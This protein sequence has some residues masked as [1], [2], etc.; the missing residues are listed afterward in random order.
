[1]SDMKNMAIIGSYDTILPFKAIGLVD[2]PVK[3]SLEAEKVLL[4]IINEGFGIIYIEEAY[5]KEFPDMI[6][7]LNKEYK[8][9]VIT[10]I[11]GSKGGHDFAIKKLGAMVK[12][13][14]GMDLL[15]DS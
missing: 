8:D 14:I 15:G 13:A 2:Y 1:M 12:K 7:N 10:I 9:V 5:A 4:K 3:E 11:P 6:L